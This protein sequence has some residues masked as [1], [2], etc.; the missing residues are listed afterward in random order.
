MK[1]STIALVAG[2]VVVASVSVTGIAAA[3][4]KDISLNVDGAA[5][6]M[7]TTAATVQDVLAKQ[8]VS[9][10][11]HDVV[12]PAAD[13]T[14]RDGTQITV[15]YGR[16][17]TAT[18]DG[19]TQ[20]FWTT[21][22]T[23]DQ[24]LAELGLL[25]DSKVSVDR[26][27]ALGREGLTFTA[28]TPKAVT[29]RHD[30]QTLNTESTHATVAELLAD[31]GIVLGDNDRVDPAPDTA[32]TTDL[33]V[34][35]QRVQVT[36]TTEKQP[37]DF[38]TTKTNSATLDKGKTQT[39]T[40]GRQGEKLVSLQIVTVDGQRES[41]KVLSEEIITE[42]VNAVVLVGTKTSTNTG[43]AA[44]AST[45][46]VNWDAIAQCESGGNW[47]INTGNGFYGGLQFTPGTWAA[48]GGTAYASRADLA[49]KAQQIAAA[50]NVL[51]TQGIGAWPTCG[52]LG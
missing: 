21:A 6:S 23:V 45:S 7:R 8:D 24:A 32:I 19:S 5:T 28:V 25:S 52:K 15:R 2:S 34:V 14:L 22:N 41:R 29:I 42:P 30:G 38:K 9:I 1:K 39:K 43:A 27:L 40:E 51:R 37:V 26:S 49:T 50:E 48:N 18:I 47:S 35:V 31:K 17:V 16:Q 3:A 10:G 12:L 13:T 11:E 20:T 33:N 36:Q 4:T 46:G 44:P